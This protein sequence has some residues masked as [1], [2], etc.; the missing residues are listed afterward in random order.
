MKLVP[1]AL[2]KLSDVVKKQLLKRMCMMNC[3]KKLMLCRLL[4]LVIYLKTRK[5]TG[6]KSVRLN[7]LNFGQNFQKRSKIEKLIITIKFKILKLV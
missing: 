6:F 5:A 1:A 7:K 2:K 4:I 3:L